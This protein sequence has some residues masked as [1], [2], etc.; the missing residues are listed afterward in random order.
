MISSSASLRCPSDHFRETCRCLCWV[1][2]SPRKGKK[3]PS[4]TAQSHPGAR[5]VLV[6]A[7]QSL[8]HMAVPGAIHHSSKHREC[9]SCTIEHSEP[10]AHR[11]DTARPQPTWNTATSVPFPVPLC[12]LEHWGYRV[13][14]TGAHQPLCSQGLGSNLSCLPSPLPSTA[15]W[16]HPHHTTHQSKPSFPPNS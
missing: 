4:G 14:P 16:P 11:A 15:P 13:C 9:G 12:S 3:H 10:S 6:Y 8:M 2:V 1:V 5:L 7:Q